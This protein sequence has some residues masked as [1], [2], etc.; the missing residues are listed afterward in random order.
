MGRIFI[1]AA[2]GGQENGVTDPG[3]VIGGTTEARE[4]I[5]TRD[6]IVTELRSRGFEILSVPD[7]LSAIQTLDWINARSRTG[8]IALEIHTDAFSNPSVR[9]SAVFYIAN[10]NQRKAQAETLLLALLRRVP[11]LPNRGTR[12]D[13]ATGLGSLAFCRQLVVP[14]LLM[15]VAVLSNPDDR[16]IIQNQRRNVALGLVDG[17]ASWSQSVSPPNPTPTP[18][19]TPTPGPGTYPPCNI[20]INGQIYAEQ[21]IVVSGNAYVPIDLVDRLGV[22]VSTDPNVRRITY[23]N[24]V[25]VRA[26]DL[27]DRHISVTWDEAKRTVSLKSNLQICPGQFD[28]IAGQGRTSEVQLLMFLKANNEAAL[29]KYPDIAKLYREEGSIEGINY[30]IAFSQMCLETDFLRFSGAVKPE[31][32]NFG[33]LG[34][35]T[36]DSQ[37]ASFSSARLGVRAQIQHLKAYANTEPL[38]QAVVDPRFNFV[39]RGVAP[40]VGQLNGRWAADPQY[41][42]KILAVLKRLYESAGLM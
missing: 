22:D 2:H 12:P 4:M 30:D 15:E 18:T 27:R 11:T 7:D 35:D 8:D 19:P 36:G 26:V 24:I 38:V 34:T 21:G 3:A 23:R 40:L 37:G 42:D 29:T 6:L 14:A 9:G 20:N 32:N 31:Q 25:Y 17:L 28:K 33:G 39:A 41:G 13:T 5:L 1:S 16:F 10:N